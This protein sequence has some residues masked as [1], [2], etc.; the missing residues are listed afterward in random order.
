MKNEGNSNDCST[1]LLKGKDESVDLIMLV[2]GG[3]TSSFLTQ[4][5]A[6]QLNCKLEEV[7]P[8]AISLA[9]GEK[10]WTH[11]YCPVFRWSINGHSFTTK[12]WILPLKDWD[13]ILG[14]NWLK[15]LGRRIPLQ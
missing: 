12:V 6:E 2:D 13:I 10:I 1:I 8:R 7:E 14:A 9:S 5:K 15:E 3:S 11:S 4:E